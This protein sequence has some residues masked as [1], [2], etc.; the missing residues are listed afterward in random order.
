[1]DGEHATGVAQPVRMILV[2]VVFA[3]RRCGP[4]VRV[5]NVGLAAGTE[6][7]FQG[8]L[9][10]R[11]HVQGYQRLRDVAVQVLWGCNSY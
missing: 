7:E 11:G 4:V 8:R 1:M 10:T 2:P 6:E 5:Q 9:C 3:H